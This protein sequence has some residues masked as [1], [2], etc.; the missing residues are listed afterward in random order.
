MLHRRVL[1][2]D[3]KG[4]REALNETQNGHGLIAKGKHW[5]FY[6]GMGFSPVCGR[7]HCLA[8]CAVSIMLYLLK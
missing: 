1:R 3:N 4:V 5:L 2:D 7:V 6:S 8:A